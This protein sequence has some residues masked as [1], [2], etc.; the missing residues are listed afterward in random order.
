[1]ERRALDAFISAAYA[2]T[3]QLVD[4]DAAAELPRGKDA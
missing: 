1:V 2:A 3:A 4:E